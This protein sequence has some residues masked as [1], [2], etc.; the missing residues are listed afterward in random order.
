MRG[1]RTDPLGDTVRTVWHPG[2]SFTDPDLCRNLFS[3][4]KS[5]KKVSVI[6]NESL[7]AGVDVWQESKHSKNTLQSG[8]FLVMV[9]DGVLEYLHVKDR[10]GKLMDIIAGGKSDNA[11][12][13][14]Q[15]ILDR[16]LLDTGG[17]AMDDMT[18]VAIGIWEK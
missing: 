1:R 11:G 14:A 6:E 9:T 16:V 13:M 3:F 18:V 5:G 17:Y 12:V 15:E 7:P 10:Q 2:I 8:D 4:I